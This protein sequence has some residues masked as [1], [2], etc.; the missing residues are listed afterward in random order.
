MHGVAVQASYGT[1]TSPPRSHPTT[2]GRRFLL[3]RSHL[4][5]LR[6]QANFLSHGQLWPA[7]GEAVVQEPVGNAPARQLHAPQVRRQEHV[8]SSKKGTKHGETD[9]SIST[10]TL[11]GAHR[12][13]YRWSKTT[14]SWTSRL[15]D[16]RSNVL[17]N[18]RQA[19]HA[20]PI[21][22]PTCLPF[23]LSFQAVDGPCPVA[24]TLLATAIAVALLS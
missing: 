19:S 9:A 17:D 23:A 6:S 13:T 14:L 20:V 18:T 10:M 16:L 7:P 1:R 24:I 12:A 8:R 21:R 4:R 5:H 15:S 22:T 11:T 3:P 2:G